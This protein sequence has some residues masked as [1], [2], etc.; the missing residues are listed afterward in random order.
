MILVIKLCDK[1]NQKSFMRS[2]HEKSDRPLVTARFMREVAKCDWIRPLRMS[3]T[4][5]S[6]CFAL[7]RQNLHGAPT[8]T[9]LENE[10]FLLN[11]LGVPG[12]GMDEAKTA[13]AVRRYASFNTFCRTG[14]KKLHQMA[15]KHGASERATTAQ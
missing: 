8:C 2:L 3:R 9:K 7:F 13:Y 15:D 12:P 4:S 14:C 11:T 6:A 1:F 5:P 10:A